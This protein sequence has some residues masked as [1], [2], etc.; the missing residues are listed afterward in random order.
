MIKRPIVWFGLAYVFG[1]ILGNIIGWAALPAFAV[2][3]AACIWICVH[4]GRRQRKGARRRWAL[5]TWL[6]FCVLPLFMFA[7]S[8]RFLEARQTARAVWAAGDFKVPVTFECT[9]EK[10]E[11]KAKSK[12]IYVKVIKED[13]DLSLPKR[14]LLVADPSETAEYGDTLVVSGCPKRFEK[15]SNPGTYD[16]WAANSM[17]GLYYQM[18]PER[19]DVI[20]HGGLPAAKALLRLKAR[21]TAVYHAVL[22]EE[23]AGVLCGIMLGDKQGLSKELKT[24]YQSQGIGH[25]FAVSGVCFLCWFFL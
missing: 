21:L 24:L 15:A 2:L 6:I 12:A 23:T 25:L 11:V 22:D 16:A 20:R 14:L 5:R 10:T 8:F 7:G 3:F 18:F 13:G 17:L 4:L 9:V 1:E 19:I